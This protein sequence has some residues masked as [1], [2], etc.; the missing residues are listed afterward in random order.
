MA[1]FTITN[2]SAS[3]SITLSSITLTA[4]GTGNDLTALTSVALYR[5][6][7]ASG[8]YDTG[9]TLYGTAGAFSGDNGTRTFSASWPSLE[10]PPRRSL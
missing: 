6:T 10:R 8:V 3:T 1:S 2:T 5:D 7:N 9:D 4:S